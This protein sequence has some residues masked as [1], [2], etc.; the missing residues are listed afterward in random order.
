MPRVSQVITQTVA[1]E[2]KLTISPKQQLTL[3]KHLQNVQMKR[4]KIKELE[5]DV[6]ASIGEVEDVLA[7]LGAEELE[8]EGFKTKIVAGVRKKFNAEKFVKKGGN[9]AIYQAAMDE[10]PVAAYVKVTPPGEKDD[11]A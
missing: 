5:K 3:R 1:V 7:D 6:K 9:L 10:L 11:D 4:K 2:Q 8:F